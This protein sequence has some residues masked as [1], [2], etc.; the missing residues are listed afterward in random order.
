MF[1]LRIVT[2]SQYQAAPIPGLDTTTSEFRGSNVKRVPVL[3]IFGSTPAGKKESVRIHRK[4]INCS[5]LL[6]CCSYFLI[7]KIVC[8]SSFQ[9]KSSQEDLVATLLVQFIP[10]FMFRSTTLF[11]PSSILSQIVSKKF[12]KYF[13]H[14]PSGIL[15]RQVSRSVFMFFQKSYMYSFRL[16]SLTSSAFFFLKDGFSLAVYT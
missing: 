8:H 6:V 15:V 7:F 9:P 14:S 4:F 16:R 12:L 1:S 3:R 5:I 10:F 2:T 11:C 13:V